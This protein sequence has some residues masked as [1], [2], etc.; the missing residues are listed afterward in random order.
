MHLPD[1]AGGFESEAGEGI[2][3]ADELDG[4]LVG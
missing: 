1:E 4:G 3:G 2:S